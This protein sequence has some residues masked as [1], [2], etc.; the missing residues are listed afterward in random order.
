MV[1][2]AGIVDP[3]AAVEERNK[4]LALGDAQVI[5]IPALSEHRMIETPRGYFNEQFQWTLAQ[6]RLRFVEQVEDGEAR[7]YYELKMKIETGAQGRPA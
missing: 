2:G 5:S 4:S 7:K 6:V 1:R 3:E